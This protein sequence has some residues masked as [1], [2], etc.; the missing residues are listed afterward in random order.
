[1][2]QEAVK[3]SIKKAR[4]G[5]TNGYRGIGVWMRGKSTGGMINW[6]ASRAFNGAI[7]NAPRARAYLPEPP[8][9][10]SIWA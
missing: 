1:M 5:L 10:R 8:C 7:L 4:Q 9:T 3:Q 6:T 2:I